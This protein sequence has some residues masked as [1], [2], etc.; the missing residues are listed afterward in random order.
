MAS[1]ITS[2]GYNP[3]VYGYL[4]QQKAI[5]LNAIIQSGI[6]MPSSFLQGKLAGGGNHYEFSDYK[7]IVHDEPHLSDESGTIVG[8]DSVEDAVQRGRIAYLNKAWAVKDFAKQIVGQNPVAAITG[9]IG[10][11]WATA[12]QK[13]IISSLIGIR[14][15]NIANDSSDMV[16]DVSN[17]NGTAVLAAERISAENLLHTK[18]TSGDHAKKYTHIIMPSL[19]YTR[20]QLLNLIAYI[21]NSRGEI[22]FTK[23]LEYTVIVDDENLLIDTSGTNR[24]KYTCI[25]CSREIIGLASGKVEVP[26]ATDRDEKT[27]NGGG[28][29][30]FHSRMSPVIHP[31]GF[32]WTDDTV[33]GKSPSVAELALPDNWDR[34]WPRKNINLAFLIVNE[35][36]K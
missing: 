27:G 22:Q 26:F 35:E 8:V 1:F 29:E 34:I 31:W 2:N 20:L 21:P 17:D 4:I 5:Q 23:F 28:E 19:M 15:D 11:Y 10:E 36:L 32:D 7:Q 24:D 12:M 9:S 14:D 16:F 13:R 33:V 25:L 18:Q 30:F 3:L 6:A